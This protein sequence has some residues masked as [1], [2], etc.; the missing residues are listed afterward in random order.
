MPDSIKALVRIIKAGTQSVNFGLAY[1]IVSLC[2]VSFVYGIFAQKYKIFPQPL[3]A[4]AARAYE[5]MRGYDSEEMMNGL[6]RFDEN[7]PQRP[8]AETLDAE[9]GDEFILITGGPY[10]FMDECPEFGCVA[11]ITDRQGNVVH[12][13]DVN[14]QEL[15]G[16]LSGFSG[17]PRIHNFHPVGIA[18][19]DDGSIYVT[20]DARNLFPYQIGMAK[21]DR[22][23][24]IL[25]KHF[26]NTHHWP[27]IGDNGLIYSPSVNTRPAFSFFANTKI[28]TG[29]DPAGFIYDE[30][31]RILDPDGSTVN[32][33]SILE[34][35][36]RADRIGFFYGIRNGCDPVHI[37]SVERVSASIAQQ[38]PE[39]EEGD[40]L[41]S[42]REINAVAILGGDSGDLKK[43]VA[44]RTAAQHS[45]RFLPDGSVL[46]VDNR[47]GDRAL[48]GTRIVRL[49]L[50]TE[51]S[52]TVFPRVAD[53]R[54]T[55]FYSSGGGLIDISPDGTRFLISLEEQPRSIEVDIATGKAVWVLHKT[56][57]ITPYLEKK[58][59]N[60]PA[61]TAHFR[62]MGAYYVSNPGFLS[63][64]D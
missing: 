38:L 14:L 58:R 39:I 24:K 6:L 61:E 21:I 31:V 62:S 3:I 64:P 16:D 59:L 46:V 8:T 9:A 7:A 1:F 19:Q 60:A 22:D 25:W 43:V 35:F 36:D 29:C 11:W 53:D 40:L 55:P 52:E 42:L 44:G 4:D 33:F 34:S 5:A 26:D 48:G 13:W 63:T 18:L 51:E 20:F 17:R 30:G 15:F 57:D 50:V 49:N 28:D 12:S 2:A 27:T 47:G 56:S 54:I 23:G 45:P 41:V 10:F 37:N 32:E